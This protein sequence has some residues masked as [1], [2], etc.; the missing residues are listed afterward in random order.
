MSAHRDALRIAAPLALVAPCS[1][2]CSQEE[3][4]ARPKAPPQLDV[5]GSGTLAW[6]QVVVRSRP[7][8][9]SPRVTVLRQFRADFRP[10]YVLALDEQ[11]GAEGDP[12]WYRVSVPGRPNGRMGWVRA[13]ALELQPVQKKLIVYRE[14]GGSSS[15]T[16]TGS[17][18]REGRS[19]QA[20]RRDPA[21]P[22]LRHLEVQPED[23]PRVVDPRRVCVRDERVF[24]A[25][26][27]AR[28]RDR[29]RPRHALARATRARGLARL[30][31]HVERERR[32]PAPADAAGHARQD[33]PLDHR[34]CRRGRCA[35]S[36]NAAGSRGSRLGSRGARAAWREHAP[37]LVLAAAITVGF[38]VNA[39]LAHATPFPRVF[40]DELI[41]MDAASSIAHG[42]GLQVREEPYVFA[43]LYPIL[44]APLLAIFDR[45]VAYEAAKMI[46]ALAFALAAVPIYLLARRPLS[47]W[48][49]VGVSALSIAI[50]S[51]M[52]TSVL[53]T[54]SV[55]YL[56]SCSALLAIALALE[57][58]TVTRQVAALALIGAATLTRPQ[59][60]V[61]YPALVVS[62]VAVPH[63]LHRRPALRQLARGIWPTLVA[64]LAG[65]GAIV[66]GPLITGG[67]ALGAY[68]VLCVD[69]H[70]SMSADT[71]STSSRISG[72]ISP[73]CHSSSHRSSSGASS[74]APGQ[75]VNARRRSSCFS[76][77]PMSPWSRWSPRSTASWA[78]TC[79]TGTSSISSRCGSSCSSTG[80]RT[81]RH[82]RGSPAALGICL[83]LLVGLVPLSG[84]GQYKAHWRFHALGSASPTEI[85]QA[86]GS[87]TATRVVL[88]TS[89]S[90][91][92]SQCSP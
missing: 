66:L 76:S 54:E 35:G 26:R 24:E 25:H 5:V 6:E 83:A 28:R 2:P 30:R 51:A 92:L 3:R 36:I 47:P 72:S 52:Y 57:K 46:N 44:L 29:R 14:R 4:S 33:R 85:N 31:A 38:L 61:L 70:L 37:H 19:R 69:T 74:S 90:Y 48:P 16:A 17:S 10:Q 49:S 7:R 50:P 34:C 39:A 21:R 62:L 84:L 65:V 79:T 82:V 23:R 55:A 53:M 20:R 89:P 40:L 12:T 27:L 81:G 8:P 71:R 41:Y 18:G 15:G 64:G 78:S 11:L 88:V 45:D 80:S 87:T 9:D 77:S 43:V 42:H 58:P 13:D 63:L 75:A 59:F 22:V 73:S 32:L 56:I 68:S 86:L 60:V 67:E 1:R 91:S